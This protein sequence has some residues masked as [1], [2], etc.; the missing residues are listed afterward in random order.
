MTKFVYWL[1]CF[2]ISFSASANDEMLDSESQ[3][4]E[5]IHTIEKEIIP[6]PNCNNET[7]IQKTKNFVIAYYNE[8]ILQNIFDRR[9]KHF[10]I[11]NIDKFVEEDIANY[12]TEKQRPVSDVLINLKINHGIIEENLRL[13]KNSSKNK[14]ASNVYLVIHPQDG[15]FKVHIINL[16]SKYDIKEEVS[17]TYK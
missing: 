12:K 13:C 16:K 1:I 10:V 14:E 4:N 8:N 15:D 17:F 5:V 11:D 3:T 2:F 7:L 9:R 6:L